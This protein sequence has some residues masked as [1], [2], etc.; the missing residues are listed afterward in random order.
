M[1]KTVYNSLCL[2]GFNNIYILLCRRRMQIHLRTITLNWSN[3][4]KAYLGVRDFKLD[5][6]FTGKYKL[7]I[8]H[9]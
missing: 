5:A 1:R 6:I 3:V 8:H 7:H 4:L 9:W 2:P